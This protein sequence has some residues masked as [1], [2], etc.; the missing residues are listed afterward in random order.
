M[1]EQ[2]PQ[3]TLNAWFNEYFI[4][5]EDADLNYERFMVQKACEWQRERDAQICETECAQNDGI[6]CA[7][8]IRKGGE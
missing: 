7:E 1:A 8:A 6:T 5:V 2:I 3:E 4:A